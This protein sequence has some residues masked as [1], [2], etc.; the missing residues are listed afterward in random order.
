MLLVGKNIDPNTIENIF[1]FVHI[2]FN[3]EKFKFFI[4]SS[5]AKPQKVL[6]KILKKMLSILCFLLILFQIICSFEQFKKNH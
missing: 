1:I 2:A 6:I 3:Y 5:C 4:Y